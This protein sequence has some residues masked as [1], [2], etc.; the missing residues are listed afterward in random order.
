[1]TPPEPRRP[2]NVPPLV[3]ECLQAIVA[4]GAGAAI[5]LGGAFALAH[6]HEYRETHDVDAWWVEPVEPEARE[7]I[8]VAVEATLAPHGDVRRRLFGEVTSVEV[9]RGAKKAFSFQIAKRSALLQPLRG[10]PWPPIRIDSFT[11]LLASKMAALVNRGAPR[12]FRDVYTL[13]T[14]GLATPAECWSLW[15]QRQ[16]ATGDSSSS[17]HAWSAASTHLARIE[18]ARPLS[19]IRDPEE[20]ARAAAIRGWFAKDFHDAALA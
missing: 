9:R 17:P 13:C 7:R 4:S 5:S 10:A 1:M 15:R 11:D 19:K 16:E 18:S 12:D 3:E 14:S 6:Y 20:K 2:A 8:V